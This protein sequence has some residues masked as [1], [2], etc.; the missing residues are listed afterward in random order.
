MSAA[1]R[2]VLLSIDGIRQSIASSMLDSNDADTINDQVGDW[3]EDLHISVPV[4]NDIVSEAE[5]AA[6]ACEVAL[7]YK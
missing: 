4:V 1:L 3:L 2:G 6:L 5:V 7:F